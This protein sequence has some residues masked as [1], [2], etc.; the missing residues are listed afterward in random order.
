M[1]RTGAQLTADHRLVLDDRVRWQARLA[2]MRPGRKVVT[3]EDEKQR[4]GV[5]AN[6]YHW[7][8]IVPYFQQVWSEGRVKLGLPPYSK[9]QAHSVLVQALVGSEPGPVPGTVTHVSTSAMNTGEFS[10]LDRAARQYAWDHY[11]SKLPE[12]NEPWEDPL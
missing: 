4:R 12:P 2:Q 5:G 9:E 6:G 7:K 3:V 11:Q 1:I 10:D 8:I